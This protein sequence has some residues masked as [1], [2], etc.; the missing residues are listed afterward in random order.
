MLWDLSAGLAGPVYQLG[1]AGLKD[2]N[3]HFCVIA[4]KSAGKR[5]AEAA[6]SP[7]LG[8]GGAEGTAG[9]TWI[10]SPAG[11]S[12]GVF[13]LSP[14]P[15]CAAGG[16]SGARA[17]PARTRL[18]AGFSFSGSSSA[19]KLGVCCAP[20]RCGTGNAA[21]GSRVPIASARILFQ[22]GEPR[23][24]REF[25]SV[26]SRDAPHPI[27]PDSHSLP[28]P[29]PRGNPKRKTST[30]TAPKNTNWLL[31]PLAPQHTQSIMRLYKVFYYSKGVG[32]IPLR[33]NYGI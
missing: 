21:A 3:E 18:R 12:S 19:P 14:D 6:G 5:R 26:H 30:H 27:P 2:S 24:G 9:S 32:M 22:R 1:A 28:K 11:F 17:A 4:M 13:L 8:A 7:R 29:A 33:F 23:P 20:A 31:A 15:V 10:K 25:S 16:N